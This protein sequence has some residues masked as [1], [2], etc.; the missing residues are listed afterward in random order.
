MGNL[1]VL[2]IYIWSFGYDQSDDV[3]ASEASGRN[4]H[5]RFTICHR[6]FLII[7]SPS[8]RYFK[9]ND[10][11]VKKRLDIFKF[12]QY[13]S[14]TVADTN[15]G[16]TKREFERIGVASWHPTSYSRHPWYRDETIFTL[17]LNLTRIYHTSS[18]GDWNKMDHRNIV[19]RF[20]LAPNQYWFILIDIVKAEVHTHSSSCK[21]LPSHGIVWWFFKFFV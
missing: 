17:H 21:L 9:F 1:I 4:R 6:Y 15:R 7:I 20:H 2:H 10:K 11:R 18:G 8:R 19:D 16:Y 3:R 12:F 5:E 13:S 14:E